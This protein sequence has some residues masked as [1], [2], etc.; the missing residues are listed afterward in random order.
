MATTRLT[1]LGDS[2]VEGRGDPDGSGAYRGWVSRFAEL[3]GLRRDQYL[4]LGAFQ[5]TTQTVV[6][7]QLRPAM[8]NKAPLVGVVVGVN[9][10]IADYVPER[11]QR[12]LERIFGSLAGDATTVFTTNYPDIPAN[13]PVPALYQALLRKRF[14]EANEQLR[15]VTRRHG[16]L[17]L[18]LAGS[19][20][21][22]QRGVWSADGLHPSP[23]GHQMFAE[24]IACAVAD[25]TG[26]SMP[27][28]VGVAVRLGA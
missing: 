12:N 20:R 24:E 25:L 5:A 27:V 2:F 26:I 6:N 1:V 10:L 17:L 22:A 3:I 14:G 19:R 8:T 4:N 11:F 16:A 28:A 13:L 21:W 23:S 9:D 18:D 15:A 7:T